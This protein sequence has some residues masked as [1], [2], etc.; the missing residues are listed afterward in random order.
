MS[1]H[2]VLTVNGELLSTVLKGLGEQPPSCTRYWEGCCP[3]CW[4]GHSSSPCATTEAISSTHVNFLKCLLFTC[5]SLCVYAHLRLFPDPPAFVF[6]LRAPLHFAFTEG[7]PCVKMP[8]T[9]FPQQGTQ[10][11]EQ[12]LASTPM[13]SA[14][15]HV[16]PCRSHESLQTPFNED[17]TYIV[18]RNRLL[19]DRSFVTLVLFLLQ[20]QCPEGSWNIGKTFK[21]TYNSLKNAS[22]NI[23]VHSDFLEVKIVTDSSKLLTSGNFFLLIPSSFWVSLPSA[24][25]V[26]EST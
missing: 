5:V 23:S 13:H 16:K 19:S 17:M 1:G 25:D 24:A 3:W 4:K 8:L 20:K 7:K 6:A 22:F 21:S 12:T 9:P 11:K 14:P 18:S 2:N 26:C 10:H 15:L